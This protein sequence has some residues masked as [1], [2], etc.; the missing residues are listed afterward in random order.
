MKH[1]LMTICCVLLTSTIVLADWAPDDG[2]KMHY[3]QL[4]DPCGL[5]VSFEAPYILADDWQCS[6][7]GPVRDIHFWVSH[8]QGEIPFL[9]DIHVE[10]FANIPAS[11]RV[12]YS[13]PGE[14]LWQ[15]DL[16]PLGEDFDY[17]SV[18][19]GTGVQGWYDPV[20]NIY[21][22]NDHDSY[23]QMNLTNIRN[24]FT[25][26][27]GEIYWL[28]ITIDTSNADGWKTS[29]DHFED[30]AVYR[31][32]T[33]GWAELKYPARHPMAGQSIDLAFVI[34]PEPATITLLSLAAFVILHRKR[35]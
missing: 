19:G 14:S 18:P 35:T 2:H 9:W 20:A 13:R 31:T 26:K 33:G 27:L 22:P 11:D 23:F 10:I 29:L 32:A 1:L 5:D 30:D 3:P 7:T 34:T 8:S 28:G 24:P 21:V 25:Q 16:F 4:P 12:P 17:K 15:A 6:W